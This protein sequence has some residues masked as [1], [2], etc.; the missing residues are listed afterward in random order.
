MSH[1]SI[2]IGEAAAHLTY[3]VETTMICIQNDQS[4]T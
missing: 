2:G 3:P 4:C 1:I